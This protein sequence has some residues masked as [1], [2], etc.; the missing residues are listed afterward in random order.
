MGRGSRYSDNDRRRA[1]QEYLASGSLAMVGEATGI[2][3]KTLSD[4]HGS[5][6]W[7]RL[8]AE[9]RQEQGEP[10]SVGEAGEV[11]ETK[12]GRTACKPEFMSEITVQGSEYTNDQRRQAV[13]EYA[14]KGSITAAAKA[15]GMPR[16]TIQSWTSTEWWAENTA[17]IRDQIGDEILATNLQIV[18]ASQSEIL[19]RVHHGDCRMMPNPDYDRGKRISKANPQ[20]I[21]VRQ[22]VSA[23]DLTITGGVAQDK[24]R[25]SLY[26]LDMKATA[27]S[28]QIDTLIKRFQA[29]SQ[30]HSEQLKASV[31]SE[32]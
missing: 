6:W 13:V 18:R 4:W 27:S 32:Q 14:V 11:I 15:L 29:I 17:K 16:T 9:L 7:N 31:V 21:E 5:E 26:G 1:V 3:R 30:A 28:D 23:R 12:F 19:D 2:P 24:A 8:S 10:Q 25:T 22:K 20:F